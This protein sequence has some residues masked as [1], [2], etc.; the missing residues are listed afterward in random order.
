MHPPDRPEGAIQLCKKAREI[1]GRDGNRTRVTR[2]TTWCL[3]HSATRPINM[4]RVVGAMSFG[5]HDCV[6]SRIIRTLERMSRG[7]GS[8]FRRNLEFYLRVS[9][10]VQADLDG[11]EIVVGRVLT[12]DQDSVCEF[13]TLIARMPREIGSSSD[14]VKSL[15]VVLVV[16]ANGQ[17]LLIDL[18]VGGNTDLS[19]EGVV[20]S[21]RLA[22]AFEP[23]ETTTDSV[24][25][26][27]NRPRIIWSYHTCCTPFWYRWWDSNPRQTG[28]M[29][30]PLYAD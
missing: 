16:R 17:E 10:A 14:F 18:T 30:P 2:T 19:G 29:R 4:V 21:L 8:F 24:H 12:E 6:S 28:L 11:A 25:P 20:G 22:M 23:F 26:V 1:G 15:E 5:T 27:Q 9:E 7:L 13:G 3:N